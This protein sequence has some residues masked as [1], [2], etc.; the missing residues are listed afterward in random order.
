[1]KDFEALTVKIQDKIKTLQ[2]EVNDLE[3]EKETKTKKVDTLGCQLEQVEQEISGMKDESDTTEILNHLVQEAEAAKQQ[4]RDL[5]ERLRRELDLLRVCQ[6]GSKAD[7]NQ[8]QIDSFVH[9]ET[10]RYMQGRL[11]LRS[12]TRCR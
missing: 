8:F 1:M 11:E 7:L 6:T 5:R 3:A 2:H 9:V 4:E 12:S 10:K